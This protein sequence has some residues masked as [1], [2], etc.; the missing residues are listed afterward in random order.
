MFDPP[1][2]VI[3]NAARTNLATGDAGIALPRNTILLPV[4][5]AFNSKSAG[6]VLA[7]RVCS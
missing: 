4:H 2:L 3:E 1:P 6:G 5:K 7:A